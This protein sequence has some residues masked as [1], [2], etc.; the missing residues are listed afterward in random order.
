MFDCIKTD[1]ELEENYMEKEAELI[2]ME[3]ELRQCAKN[4]FEGLLSTRV[5]S[6]R[7]SV[8]ESR[9]MLKDLSKKREE[10][11]ENRHRFEVDM[12]NTEKLEKRR[13]DVSLETEQNLQAVKNNLTSTQK[14]LTTLERTKKDLELALMATTEERRLFERELLAL[15]EHLQF[16]ANGQTNFCTFNN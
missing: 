14:Q 10:V 1:F 9:Q 5:V 2:R 16:K 15:R 6:L 11:T 4:D 7:R 12:K 8:E 13:L 3:N